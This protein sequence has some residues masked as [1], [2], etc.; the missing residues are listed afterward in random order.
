MVNMVLKSLLKTKRKGIKRFNLFLLV[1]KMLVHI[2]GALVLLQ[3][4]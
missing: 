4:T 1:G 2:L 3:K